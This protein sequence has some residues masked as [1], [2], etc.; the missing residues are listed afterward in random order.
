MSSEVELQGELDNTRADAG[1]NNLPEVGGLH[2][3]DWVGEA[4]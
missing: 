2:D 4:G 1:G 3:A